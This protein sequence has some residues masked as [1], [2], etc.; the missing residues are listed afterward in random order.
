MKTR[1][2]ADFFLEYLYTGNCLSFTLET[3]AESSSS[4]P[5]EPFAILDLVTLAIMEGLTDLLRLSLCFIL[6]R[7]MRVETVT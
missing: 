6:T 3:I 7:A 1:K 4:P 2:A 5:D